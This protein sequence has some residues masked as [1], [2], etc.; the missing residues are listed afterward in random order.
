MKTNI[1][2]SVI[3][4]LCIVLLMFTACD[5]F[6]TQYPQSENTTEIFY[7]SQQDFEYAI[8]GVYAAQQPLFSSTGG[9]IRLSITRSDDLRIRTDDGYCDNND[10]F[11]DGANASTISAVWQG[12]YK[13]IYRSNAILDRID[14]VKFN[15]ET[16]K[17]YIKGEALA[18]RAWSYY[19]LGTWFGGV[20]RIDKV[21]TLAETYKVPRSTQQETL[22]YAKSDYEAAIE[23]LP[24]EWS[25]N[26][27]GRITKYAAMGGLARLLMFNRDWVNASNYLGQIMESG[28]YGLAEKYEDC[29][30]DA[31]NNTKERLWEVQ[32]MTGVAG[33]GNILGNSFIPEKVDSMYVAGC[34]LPGSSAAVIVSTDFVNAYEEGDKRKEQTLVT[35]FS[36]GGSITHEYYC[37]KWLHA[38][39]TPINHDGFGMNIPI[40]RYADVLLMYAE[41]KNELGTLTQ[42]D[43]DKTLNAVR[44]RAGL[45]EVELSGPDVDGIRNKII[46]ERRMEFAF[47]GLR[48]WDLVRWGKAKEVMDAFLALSENQNGTY[49]MADFRTIYAI[50]AQE[51]AN[52]ND[53]TV[54]WQNEGY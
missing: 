22:D 37:R 14:S 7:K 40:I 27:K 41:C 4:V 12:V 36:Y 30:S 44:K 23:L 3:P 45:N 24:D 48:W 17:K 49:T 5:K 9:V 46:R 11:I 21:L 28:K 15:D 29:F 47:E 8:A 19:T 35:D 38:T 32:F 43:L 13:M 20:P 16:L 10:K 1:K 52:Y 31:F 39:K 50:P 33:E 34:K 6:L 25:G 2:L 42:A 53:K 51:I 18:L 26:N 54:M